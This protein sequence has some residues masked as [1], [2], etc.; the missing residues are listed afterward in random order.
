MLADKDNSC[1]S[2]HVQL[3]CVFI[4]QYSNKDDIIST[5]EAQM[6]WGPKVSKLGIRPPFA[7]P[8]SRVY[9]VSMSLLPI[10]NRWVFPFS[11]FSCLLFTDKCCHV[12]IVNQRWTV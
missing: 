4:S 8:W 11:S 5:G 7:S 1:S 2:L 10:S 9:G 12:V 3:T 6:G